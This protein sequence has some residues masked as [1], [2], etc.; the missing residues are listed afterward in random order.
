[1]KTTKGCASKIEHI[2]V[3]VGAR[4]PITNDDCKGLD[5]KITELGVEGFH[6]VCANDNFVFFTKIT[7]PDTIEPIDDA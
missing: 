6:L 2:G 1:M 7:Y 5:K 3:F 4:G